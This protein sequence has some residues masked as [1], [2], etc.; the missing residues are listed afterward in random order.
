MSMGINICP[1]SMPAVV[2]QYLSKFSALWV[3]PLQ[4]HDYGDGQYPSKV[5]TCLSGVISI[6]IE[7][8]L[9]WARARQKSLLVNMGQHH[10]DSVLV[11]ARQFHLNDLAV[12]A[13]ATSSQTR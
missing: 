8:S 4:S 10:S 12:R 1:N 11:A 2:G 3:Y 6:H 9:Q 7:Y 13:E 5:H